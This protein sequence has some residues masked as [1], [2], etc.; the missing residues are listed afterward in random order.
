VL[1]CCSVFSILPLVSNY[2]W[3]TVYQCGFAVGS[4][5]IFG[6]TTTDKASRPLELSTCITIQLM[7]ETGNRI[8]TFSLSLH[9][10]S[11]IYSQNVTPS[12]KF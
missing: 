6:V 11:F 7:D 12:S 3:V 9:K 1:C 8:P 4:C 2:C 5:L 10:S